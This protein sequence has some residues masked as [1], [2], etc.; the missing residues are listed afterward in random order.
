MTYSSQTPM[1]VSRKIASKMRM[2]SL[3]MP[4]STTALRNWKR[5]S[6]AVGWMGPRNTDRESGAAAELSHTSL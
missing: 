4:P 6:A 2:R 5:N 1:K 3:F